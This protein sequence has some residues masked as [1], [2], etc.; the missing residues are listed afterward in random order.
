MD[1]RAESDRETQKRIFDLIFKLIS[2]QPAI[3]TDRKKN[4]KAKI[5]LLKM[6]VVVVLV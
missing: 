1:A 2:I 3:G 5:H 4:W 6:N